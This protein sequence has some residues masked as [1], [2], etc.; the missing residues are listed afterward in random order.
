MLRLT[1]AAASFENRMTI[2]SA[3]ILGQPDQYAVHMAIELLEA[4]LSKNLVD[5]T[6][7]INDSST[8]MPG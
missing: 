3:T 6:S 8:N 1:I 2:V 5:T 4:I 7:E